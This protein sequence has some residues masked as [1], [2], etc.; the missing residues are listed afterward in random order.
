MP[1]ARDMTAADTRTGPRLDRLTFHTSRALDFCNEKGLITETGHQPEV[2]PLVAVK[3]L[4]DNATAVISSCPS[5][6]RQAQP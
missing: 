1:E 2:W 4:I 3:E 5:R 6:R